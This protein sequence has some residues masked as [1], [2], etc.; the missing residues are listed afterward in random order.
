MLNCSR[1]S[2]VVLDLKLANDVWNFE[3]ALQEFNSKFK[4]RSQGQNHW[5]EA[6]KATSVW[7]SAVSAAEY[8]LPQWRNRLA[9]GTYRQYV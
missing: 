2:E 3:K 9:H 1:I 8:R 4:G 5:R 7:Y 6:A